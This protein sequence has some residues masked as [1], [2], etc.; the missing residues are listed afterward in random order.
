MG[1]YFFCIFIFAKARTFIGSSP[2]KTP[3]PYA[4][5]LSKFLFANKDFLY[6]TKARDQNLTWH[7]RDI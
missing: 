4:L 6:I 3:M 7:T 5:S 2:S 1:F